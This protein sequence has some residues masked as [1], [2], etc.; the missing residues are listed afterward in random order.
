MER[1]TTKIHQNSDQFD[2]LLSTLG[3]YLVLFAR[4]VAI[5][6][7]SSAIYFCAPRISGTTT[8]TDHQ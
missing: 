4:G 8:R 7:D 2:D 1:E 6:M 5:V 3:D